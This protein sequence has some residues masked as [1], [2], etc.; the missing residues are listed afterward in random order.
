MQRATIIDR[1]KRRRKFLV[2]SPGRKGEMRLSLKGMALLCAIDAGMIRE[3]SDGSYDD[4]PFL[5]FWDEFSRFIKADRGGY[6]DEIRNVA[7][8]LQKE[9]EK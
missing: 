9:K 6:P 3:A 8:L 2:F 1:L 4:E 7:K 5:R